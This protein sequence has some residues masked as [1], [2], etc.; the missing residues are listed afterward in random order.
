MTVVQD[1]GGEIL[2]ALLLKLVRFR[3]S[4]YRKN[5]WRIIP[6]GFLGP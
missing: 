5:Y 4:E 3:D 1:K 6:I 2:V